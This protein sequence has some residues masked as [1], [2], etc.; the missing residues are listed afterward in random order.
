MTLGND[1]KATKLPEFASF[2]SQI[3]KATPSG[4]DSSAYSPTNSAQSCPTIGSTWEAVEKLPPSPNEQICDCMMQN[5]TCK[6]ADD[7]S[8]DDVKTQF[9]YIC[10]PKLGDFC[11]GVT[12]DAGTGTYGAYS[13]CDAVQRL[14]WA[15]NTYYFDQKEIDTA[16]DFKKTATKQTPKAPSSC[17][18]VA[19]QAGPAGTGVITS[20]PSGTGSGSSTA[21]PSKKNAA[22]SVTI[23]S[24][25]FGTLQL[26]AYMTIAALAG[27]GIVLL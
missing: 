27:A 6:A 17:K 24:F 3:V 10:N 12:A 15:F 18:N 19:D 2:S 5:L 9:D 22:G 4:V 14:S 20:A 25:S 13:M 26:T 21:T 8:D 7:I 16:C 23:P 1:K 11:S